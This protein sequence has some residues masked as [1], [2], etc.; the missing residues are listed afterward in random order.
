MI[1]QRDIIEKIHTK[2]MWCATPEG[3]DEV[4]LVTLNSRGVREGKQKKY[5]LEVYP[6]REVF[7]REREPNQPSIQILNARL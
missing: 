7:L 3:Q 2:I 1:P 5:F 6:I 4:E